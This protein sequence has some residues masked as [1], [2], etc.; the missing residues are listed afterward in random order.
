MNMIV[1]LGNPGHEYEKSKHNTGFRVVDELAAQ[2][3]VTVWQSKMNAAVASVPMDGRKILLVKPQTYMNNSGDAVGALMRWYKL[4][5]TDVYVIYDDMDLPVGK[6]RIRT[7]GSDG[8]HNGIKSLFANGVRD[9]IRF[10]V[11]IGRPLPH[12]DVID[13]V[14]TPFPIELQE[15]YQK[16]IKAA[17]AAVEGC[18]E[19]GI[20]KG[21][22]RFNSKKK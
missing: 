11:G 18:L 8:G 5:E 1:G 4:A 9:F 19:L 15:P 2:W 17:A 12:H 14:L 22:N 21:M 7:T 6:L 16:G 20:S 13:H 3:H 10:R